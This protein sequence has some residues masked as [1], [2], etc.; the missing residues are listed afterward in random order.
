MSQVKKKMT[1]SK[2]NFTIAWKN[3][4]MPPNAV[5]ILLGDFNAGEQTHGGTTG[6]AVSMI[7]QMS[8]AHVSLTLQG[9]RINHKI[10]MISTQV[11]SQ[12]DMDVPR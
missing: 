9:T 2:S 3:Y 10:D 5:K 4:T 1:K 8:M 11:H 6:G 7:Y 12:K